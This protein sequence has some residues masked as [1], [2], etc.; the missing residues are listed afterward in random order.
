MDQIKSAIGE[1]PN[2]E[3]ITTIFSGVFE[4]MN[5]N[6]WKGAC[7]ESCA[8]IHILLNEMGVEN[9][10]NLGEAKIDGA[11]FDHSWIEIGGKKFD[12]AISKPLEDYLQAGAVI[13]DIDISTNQ[14]TKIEYGVVSGHEDHLMTVAF[15]TVKSLSAYL[16]SS[17]MHPE[18]G[19]WMLIDQLS[20]RKLKKTFNIPELIKKYNGTFY[21][22]VP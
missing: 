17:P 18:L 4:L 8:A 13:N 22:V 12:L 2:H 7:H 5:L 6:D 16:L 21:N 3:T 1:I 15:K 11:F 14:P 9:N 20:K 10:W 19:T